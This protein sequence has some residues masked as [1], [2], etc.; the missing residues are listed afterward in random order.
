MG[1]KWT[2]EKKASPNPSE[3]RGASFL[4]FLDDVSEGFSALS[5][6]SGVGGAG[7][8]PRYSVTRYTLHFYISH[9]N[10]GV[11]I[12]EFKGKKA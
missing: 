4:L 2:S 11:K 6:F 12:V 5:P 1:N 10:K 7:G 9:V 3:R 8:F